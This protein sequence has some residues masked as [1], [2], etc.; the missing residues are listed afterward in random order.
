MKSRWWKWDETR[1]HTEEEAERH[2]DVEYPVLIPTLIKWQLWAYL[3]QTH[4]CLDKL[5]VK[6]TEFQY[7]P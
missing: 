3:L 1:T 2:R 6:V 5:E 4:I 7:M